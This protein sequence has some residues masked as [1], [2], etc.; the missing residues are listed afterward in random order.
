M[1]DGPFDVTIDGAAA[2]EALFAEAAY[3]LQ[4]DTDRAT[5]AAA[6]EAV[7]AMHREHPYTDRTYNLSMSMHAEPKLVAGEE[8][9]AVIH[10]EASYASYVDRKRRFNFTK[11]AERTAERV[12]NQEEREA[13]RRYEQK[14]NRG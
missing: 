9:S 11:L 6:D 2:L 4:G 3:S 8:H 13:V 1:D 7:T 14:V 12:L 10:V 5:L